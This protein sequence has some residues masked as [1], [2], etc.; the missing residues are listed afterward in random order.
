MKLEPTGERMILEHYKSSPEDYVIYLIHMASY[1]FAEQFTRGKRVL[2]FGCGSGYGSAQIA[3]TADHVTALDVAE[4]AVA[5]AREQFPRD[6]LEFRS[7]DPAE[8]LPFADASFD[9]ILSFQVFEHVTH[10]SH[11]LAEIRRVLMPGGQ[12]VLITPD[13]STRLLPFQRPWNR[14][15]VREYSKRELRGLLTKHFSQVD[16]LGMTAKPEMIGFELR[17]CNRAKWAMLPCTLPIMPDSW[18]VAC[19]NMVHRIRGRRT[20]QPREYPFSVEDVHIGPEA[21]P[22]VNLVAVAS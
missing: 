3:Q 4:D 6:N 9:V 22:S 8:T 1:R 5:Y 21:S 18:R 19:L 15:H 7:I 16:V 17:R 20:G 2:D 13:R 10:T 12:L 11:Y 14:W